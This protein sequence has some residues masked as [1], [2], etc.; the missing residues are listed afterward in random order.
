MDPICSIPALKF[1]NIL[2]YLLYVKIY[3]STFKQIIEKRA[4]LPD[5]PKY[6]IL[7]QS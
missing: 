4:F 3:L 6:E 5:V 2:E 7:E 1:F